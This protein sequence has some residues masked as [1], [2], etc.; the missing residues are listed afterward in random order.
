M[1]IDRLRYLLYIDGEKPEELIQNTVLRAGKHILCMDKARDG[2]A[3]EYVDRSIRKDAFTI[4]VTTPEGNVV[5]LISCDVP[6]KS[7]KFIY[8]SL[9]CAVDDAKGLGARLLDIVLWIAKQNH[10]PYLKLSTA[11]TK[12]R[13]YYQKRGFIVCNARR[14]Q[15][16]RQELPHHDRLE[17]NTLIDVIA[18]ELGV[19]VEAGWKSVLNHALTTLRLPPPPF[20]ERPITTA[21]RVYDHIRTNSWCTRHE[22]YFTQ[23]NLDSYDNVNPNWNEYTMTKCVKSA[24]LHRDTESIARTKV[25]GMRRL[26]EVVFG[27]EIDAR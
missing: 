6:L 7:T 20:F 13:A 27:Y 2:V 4:F 1:N 3:R 9:L 25:T 16:P 11:N 22:T 12:L 21:R 10:Y 24:V 15:C 18:D 5:G 17:F 26:F 19:D 23:E 8:I 14:M